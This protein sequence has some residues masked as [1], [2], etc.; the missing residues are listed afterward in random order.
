MNAMVYDEPHKLR[1]AMLAFVVHGAFFALLYFGFSWQTQPSATMSVELWQSLPDA[2][3]APPVRHI[4][5]EVVP[6]PQPEQTVKPDIALPD[7]KKVEARPVVPKRVEKKPAEIGKIG[8]ISPIGIPN[9][10]S[11]QV[12]REQ[13][14]KAAVAGRVMDEYTGKIHD[15][16][17]RNVPDIQN[18]PDDAR[19]EFSVTL[20]PGG[21]VLN[22]RL[23]KSSGNAAYD[24][25]V[26]RAIWKSQPLPLPPDAAMFSKFR[27]LNL[28]FM[29][30][31]KKKER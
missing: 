6:P 18:V 25:A 19:A 29:P 9:R 1:A 4:V 11:A 20:L 10:Q 30:E 26:E 5:E 17:W 24:N 13:A 15:K 8:I 31:P 27:E 16:I 22:V 14:E 2:A 23:T 21:M 28:G 7:K 12:G 3:A